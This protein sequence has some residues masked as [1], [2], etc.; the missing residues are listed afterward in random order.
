MKF[1]NMFLVGY[2]VL[3]IGICLA[4]WQGGVMDDIGGTWLGI[5][6]VVAI[7]IGI[8]MAVSSGKPTGTAGA[9]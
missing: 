2:V 6:A 5:G 4:L 8:M 1:I 7:G 3:I 9:R